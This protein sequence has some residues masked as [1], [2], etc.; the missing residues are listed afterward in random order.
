[1]E[2]MP[3]RILKFEVFASKPPYLKAYN[4][5]QDKAT[6][7]KFCRVFTEGHKSKK[8]SF[9]IQLLSSVLIYGAMIHKKP[10]FHCH[11]NE[12]FYF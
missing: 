9:L 5:L 2:S 7:H 6:A 12:Y 11:M 1:M 4:F 10:I 3:F 8:Y